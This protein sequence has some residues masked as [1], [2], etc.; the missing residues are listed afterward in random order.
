MMWNIFY[1]VLLGFLLAQ[2]ATLVTTVYLHRSST[3]QSVTFHPAIEFVFQLV[4][5]LT[6]GINRVEWVA[7]HI[8]HHLH[9]ETEEDPHSPIV[10]GFWEVQLWNPFLYQKAARN[11]KVMR[12]GNHLKQSWAELAIFSSPLAGLIIGIIVA[13]W[14]FGWKS[15]LI[16]STIHALL[17]LFFL[18]NL[19]NGLCHWSGYKNFPKAHAFN[20]RWVA[21]I[22]AGEGNHNNHHAIPDSPKLSLRSDEPDFGWSLIWML[23]FFGLAQ[24]KTGV[25]V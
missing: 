17:Y 16:L 12:Y 8:Y 18:N 3:H 13:C 7:V 2:V 5:W 11:P 4:L 6:T 21:W 15:G 24:V 25:R 1:P 9:T 20:N 19:V 23:E 22:T 10:L 14:I